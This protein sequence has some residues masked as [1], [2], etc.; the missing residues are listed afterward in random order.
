MFQ[1]GCWPFDD[2]L[3]KRT[4][5][6]KG[7]LHPNKIISA[8]LSGLAAV[9]K[10]PQKLLCLFCAA[11]SSIRLVKW[12]LLSLPL[13]GRLVQK[14][15][16]SWTEIWGVLSP[17]LPVFALCEPGSGKLLKGQIPKGRLWICH[18]CPVWCERTAAAVLQTQALPDAV[19][20]SVEMVPIPES[21]L[22]PHVQWFHFTR[23]CVLFKPSFALL[24][25]CLHVCVWGGLR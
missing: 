25:A 13:Q 9:L 16:K 21:N 17:E 6:P 5:Y 11:L 14:N 3:Y 12:S 20:I 7:C 22:H 15:K 24:F 1:P 2:H 19:W 18:T 23:V 10:H 8:T 4:L